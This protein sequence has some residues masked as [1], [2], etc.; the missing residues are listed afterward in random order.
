MQSPRDMPAALRAA[1]EG[2]VRDVPGVEAAVLFGSR[3]RGDHR[4]DSDWDLALVT[5]GELDGE[6]R[7]AALARFRLDGLQ[8]EAVALPADWLRLKAGALGT[9]ACP[10]AREGRVIAGA[11]DRPKPEG[12][13]AMEPEVYRTFIENALRYLR[14]AA[15]RMAALSSGPGAAIARAD[16]RQ[17]VAES[18]DAAEHLVKAMRGCVA[19]AGGWGHNLATLAAPL[20]DAG[21]ADLYREVEA[22]NGGSDDDHQAGYGAAARRPP[23]RREAER[24]ARRL[25]GTA[26]LLAVE[27][28]E[29][30]EGGPFAAIAMEAAGEAAAIFTEAAEALRAADARGPAASGDPLANAVAAGGPVLADALEAAAAAL[31]RERQSDA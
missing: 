27:L 17:V 2:A 5:A 15:S 12:T 7:A 23:G 6:A 3:A 13:P 26:R 4:P 28:R 1:A 16:S 8:V 20:L 29:A 24:A 14:D 22:L 21:R 19:G 11:W 18:A 9:L 25:A 30:A 31:G 10:I